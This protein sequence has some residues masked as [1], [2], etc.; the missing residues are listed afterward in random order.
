MHQS[1]KRLPPLAIDY[2]NTHCRCAIYDPIT[3]EVD[4]F[5][6]SS[7]DDGLRRYIHSY[8]AFN[9]DPPL[10]GNLARVEA[11]RNP[12]HSVCWVKRLL[13]RRPSDV[14]RLTSGLCCQVGIYYDGMSEYLK[15]NE[16]QYLTEE[17]AAMLLSRLRE[18]A[19]ERLERRV[20][21]TLITVPAC[22]N[23]AQREA[24]VNAAEIAGFYRVHLLNET[25]AASIAYA[26][27]NVVA[28][29]DPKNVVFYDLGGGHVSVLVCRITSTQCRVLGTAGTIAL[30]GDNFDECVATKLA[31]EF[32]RTR[33]VDV[34]GNRRD[35]MRLRLAC[36]RAKRILSYEQSATIK[37]TDLS[38][39]PT[40]TRSLTRT[41]FDSMCWELFESAVKPVTD[42]LEVANLSK[43]DVDD[44]VIL[45]GASRMP[46]LQALLRNIFHQKELNKTFHSEETIV[47]GAA[48]YAA[49][50]TKLSPNLLDVCDVLAYAISMEQP[51]GT[52]HTLIS[53]NTPIPCVVRVALSKS[54]ASLESHPEVRLYEG[55]HALASDNRYLGSFKLSNL[56]A[57]SDTSTVELILTPSGILKVKRLDELLAVE[58]TGLSAS[59]KSAAKRRF[60]SKLASNTSVVILKKQRR[61]LEKLICNLR[62]TTQAPDAHVNEVDRDYI[63][64]CTAILFTWL[65]R[66][67]QA[68]LAEVENKIR[69]VK[70]IANRLTSNS[71]SPQL[72]SPTSLRQK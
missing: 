26:A 29:K 45:G 51:K 66:H 15:F 13:G 38:T 50:K 18:M 11:M 55:Q 48:L 23:D 41:E 1:S 28:L 36:E 47:V 39:P 70:G 22:F 61:H 8:V 27:C 42:A 43:Y 2:G 67:Q 35:F 32:E 6:D 34:R 30:G 33:G 64:S 20:N 9:T 58:K 17:I 4:I 10:V 68:T 57:S 62:L 53:P 63:H 12:N 59:M 5:T 71:R 44:V 7:V 14:T 46:Q 65:S 54:L 3:E 52:C 19:E 24:I 37:M 40:F 25:T 31:E 56:Q 60:T 69:E 21:T 16:D 72:W 49:R